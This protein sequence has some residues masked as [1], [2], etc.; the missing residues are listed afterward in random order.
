MLDLVCRQDYEGGARV[1]TLPCLH[2]RMYAHVVAYLH[3]HMCVQSF[4]ADCVRPLLRLQAAK[5][6]KDMLRLSLCLLCGSVQSFLMIRISL[7]PSKTALVPLSIRLSMCPSILLSI[8]PYPP[9]LSPS[10]L[11]SPFLVL[12]RAPSSMYTIECGQVDQWLSLNRHCP[13]CKHRV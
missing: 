12:F 7:D 10:S 11:P 9:T 3:E 4:H 2:V 8:H 5:S 6:L 13:T 1:K